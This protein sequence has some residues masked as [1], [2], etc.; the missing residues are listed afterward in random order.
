MRQGSGGRR[1]RGRPHRKQHIS[2][3]SQTFD[4][5]GPEGRVRGNAH[6]VYEKYLAL[7]R[8]ATSAGDRIAAEGFYQ[9]AEHY[10]RLVNDST[11]P[12]FGG[13]D[14]RRGEQRF[15]QRDGQERGPQPGPAHEGGR[16]N[17]AE[18]DGEQETRGANGESAAPRADRETEARSGDSDDGADSAPRRRAPRRRRS[19]AGNGAGDDADGESQEPSADNEPE[20]A[21]T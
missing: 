17:G 1:P 16:P 6:Q 14:Q 18:S 12:H 3:R 21:A 13:S 9:F 19:A 20:A 4:S 11:D 8:D 7:A 5:N 2:P 10:F 15:D